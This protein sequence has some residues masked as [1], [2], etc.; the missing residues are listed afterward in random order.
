MSMNSR[1]K[2]VCDTILKYRDHKE[3]IIRRTVINLLPRLAAFAPEEFAAKYLDVCMQALLGV[4]KK[5]GRGEERASAFLV[6]GQIAHSVGPGIEP[7]RPQL[8]ALIKNALDV[9]NRGYC[10]QSLTCWSMVSSA[11]GAAVQQDMPEMLDLMFKSG[12]SPELTEALTELAAHSPSTLPNIQEK[13]MNQLSWVL[14]GKTF[15]YPGNRTN[16]F[17]HMQQDTQSNFTQPV[18]T[19]VTRHTAHGTRND[20]RHTHTTHTTRAQ[21]KAKLTQ[22]GRH[23]H[24]WREMQ[25]FS[26][27]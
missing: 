25:Q 8:T 1:F 4:L 7:Y 22:R 20:A 18:N 11:L 24:T 26:W 16:I 23:R 21:S 12:L 15:V 19:H 6:L 14:A 27:H 5:D 9:R 13:L 17:S 10:L 2:D 3:R